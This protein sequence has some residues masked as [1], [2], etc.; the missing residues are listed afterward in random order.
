MSGLRLPAME[1][2]EMLDVMHYLMEEDNHQDRDAAAAQTE[3][4]KVLY[5]ELYNREYKYGYV[6]KGSKETDYDALDDPA[7]GWGE[8]E[9]IQPFDPTTPR[10]VKP[11]VEPTEFD[12]DSSDP[13]GG[14]LD[15]PVGG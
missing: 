2:T 9:D 12:P 13:F 1:A 7:N 14:L 11:Y 3:A 4:R 6:G 10:T 15:G 5:K 8:F